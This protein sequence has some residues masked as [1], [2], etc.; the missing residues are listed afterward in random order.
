MTAN[1]LANKLT[2][3]LKSYIKQRGFV[4]SGKLLSSINFTITPPPNFDIKLEAEEYIQYLDKGKLLDDFL[5]TQA[6]SD[7]IE[8]YINSLIDELGNNF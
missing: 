1:D 7:T 8:E 6:V 2:S 4:A 3:L 5:S